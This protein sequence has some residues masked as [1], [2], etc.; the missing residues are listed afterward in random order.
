MKMRP[1]NPPASP[2][3]AA[4]DSPVDAILAGQARRSFALDDDGII[5][6]LPKRAQELHAISASIVRARVQ[7]RRDPRFPRIEG[8]EKEAGCRGSNVL[9]PG[10]FLFCCV[11]LFSV[12]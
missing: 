3:R 5:R 11:V 12:G 4:V 10:C 8:Y 7:M 1:T 2:R 9:S 6:F